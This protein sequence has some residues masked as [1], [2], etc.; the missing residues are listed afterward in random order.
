MDP[1]GS[2]IKGKA[3]RKNPGAKDPNDLLMRSRGTNSQDMSVR[4][5][6]Q[7]LAHSHGLSV[8]GSVIFAAC[9]W[10]S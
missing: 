5:F 2:R 7:H 4:I 6:N 8:G 3:K 9:A 1:R 10:Y